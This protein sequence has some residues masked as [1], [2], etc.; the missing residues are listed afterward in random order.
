MIQG[1]GVASTQY[2]KGLGW[3]RR[4]RSFN[5]VNLGGLERVCRVGA[6]RGVG[7]QHRFFSRVWVSSRVLVEREG[8]GGCCSCISYH[9]R[10]GVYI[11]IDRPSCRSYL[12]GVIS[13]TTRHTYTWE[14]NVIGKGVSVPP[15]SSC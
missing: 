5:L 13:T 9:V 12:E 11:Y 7:D 2:F 1:F 6:R 4:E 15:P 14:N 8:R 10:E 3:P